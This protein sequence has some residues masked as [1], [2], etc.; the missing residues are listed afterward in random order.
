MHF[1]AEIKLVFVIVLQPK[2]AE[3]TGTGLLCGR[4][5]CLR[6]TKKKNNS[7]FF[8]TL[9]FKFSFS[10]FSP[11]AAK[12]VVEFCVEGLMMI[13][14]SLPGLTSKDLSLTLK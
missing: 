11:R 12:L 9:K 3:R 1:A 4:E 6:V 8:F 10:E 7:L 5:D 14:T 2:W 13:L